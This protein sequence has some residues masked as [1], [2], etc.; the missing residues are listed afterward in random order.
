MVRLSFGLTSSGSSDIS[1]REDCRCFYSL[2]FGNG[3]VNQDEA[4]LSH[5]SR[6]QTSTV[7]APDTDPLLCNVGQLPF[8]VPSG[9]LVAW[10]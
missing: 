8:T 3:D 6:R 4:E 2:R 5:P 1:V 9:M 10:G 7:I